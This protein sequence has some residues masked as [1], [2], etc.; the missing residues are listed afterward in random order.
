[1]A[2]RIILFQTVIKAVCHAPFVV[3]E[4]IQM[5]VSGTRKDKNWSGVEAAPYITRLTPLPPS[6]RLDWLEKVD[7]KN[8][9]IG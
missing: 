7:T 8:V 2:T 5:I 4:G 3:V 6:L 9:L 1:V